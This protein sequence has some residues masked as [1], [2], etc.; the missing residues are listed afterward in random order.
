MIHVLSLGA[1]VQSTTLALMAAHGEVTPMPTAAIFADTQAEPATVYQHLDWLEGM[2]P[3]PVY[4]VTAGSLRDDLLAG[5]RSS[6]R[7]HVQRRPPFFVAVAGQAKSG[8]LW[9]ECTREYKIKP[10]LREVR[11]LAGI[12]P[13][14]SGP[15]TPIVTQW[16]G[17]SRDEVTRMKPSQTRWIVHRWPLIDLSMTRYQCLQWL[18]AHGYPEPHKSACT[19][20][21]YHDN[22]QW[23]HLRETSPAEWGE[24]VAFDAAIRNGGVHQRSAL[25]WYVHASC[26][27][28]DEVDL[29]TPEDHGQLTMFDEECAGVCGV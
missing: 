10:I 14:S 2:L 4:R 12:K 16:I 17:I 5:I 8:M 11:R 26:V 29:S 19:F 3:F 21:P 23:R 6:D 25:R 15:R 24:T 18:K 7:L 20:C 9:R 27:P 28:L 1:G 22:A 13:H